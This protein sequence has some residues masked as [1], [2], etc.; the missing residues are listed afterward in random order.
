MI[1]GALSILD[2]VCSESASENAYE[3]TMYLIGN[4]IQSLAAYGLD[5]YAPDGSYIES[6]THW[7]EATSS[8]FRMAMALE[9]AAG[10]DYGFLDTWGMEKTCY[11]SIHVQNSEGFI[12]NYH[13][14]VEGATLN[15]D[16][17]FYAGMCYGDENLVAVRQ[18]QLA[19]GKEITIYD[20][21]FYPIGKTVKAPE[22]SLD[23]HMEAIE[24]YVSRS[25]WNS[26]A[27]Y[28]GLMGGRNDATNAQ[29]DSG[30][31]IYQNK[32]V[33]WI[34]DLGSENPYVD[35][36]T[37]PALRYKFYRNSSEGQNVIIKTDDTKVPYGQNVSAG[38]YITETFTNEH[39]SYVLLDNTDVYRN[40]ET[41]RGTSEI[42]HARRGVLFTNDRSTVVLQDE[43]AFVF[44]GSATWVV[45]TKADIIVDNSGRVAYMT[46]VGIDGTTYTVRAT[47]VSKNP[48]FKFRVESA[49]T[50]LLSSGLTEPNKDE[51]SRD[52]YKRL[53][54]EVSNVTL[55]EMA[56]VFELVENTKD[57]TPVAYSWTSMFD[58]EPKEYNPDDYSAATE[59]RTEPAKEE[60][61][62]YAET[63]K[64]F[65]RKANVYTKSLVQLYKTLTDAGY[66]LS[67]YPETKEENA[68][69]YSDY[70]GYV[71]KY[72]SF[73]A[74][75]N[76]ASGFAADLALAI[77]GIRSASGA[78]TGE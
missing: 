51:L 73:V 41:N 44:N 57:Q 50:P 78:E 38:G 28:T 53:L 75:V 32:G 74:Y 27:I 67:I 20:L 72:E 56:V 3:E 26:G 70:I 66:L 25:E 30:N 39:G 65:L 12:W 9:S 31:F 4:N 60:L 36:I 34:V 5:I 71:K 37:D 1:I 68:A 7:E 43:I 61:D 55:F 13:D 54:V 59:V 77:S 15:T 24:G 17:F 10:T 22:L 6:A 2:Y 33:S 11:Y 8:F 58:W 64:S 69:K 76:G 49:T 47:I 19:A 18:Q 14:S 21:L 23:Y 48:N 62:N 63:A 35:G 42:S 46:K 45:H 40:G 29:L 16:M 52:S